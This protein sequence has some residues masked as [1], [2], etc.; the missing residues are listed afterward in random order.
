MTDDARLRRSRNGKTFHL[1]TC[2]RAQNTVPWTWAEEQLLGSG[3]PDLIIAA[4]CRA[5]GV[6]PCQV[7]HPDEQLGR[8]AREVPR[9]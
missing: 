1:A 4:V 5:N 7:C 6:H 9:A 8:L 3:H 2:V